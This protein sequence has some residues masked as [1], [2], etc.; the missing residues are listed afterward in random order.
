MANQLRCVKKPGKPE[1]WRDVFFVNS[2]NIGDD[3]GHGHIVLDPDNNVHYY[4]D[5]WQEHRDENGRRDD[6]LID[7]DADIKKQGDTHR[8]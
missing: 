3:I 6:F 1:G 2:G 5:V 8:I 7:E 4:R